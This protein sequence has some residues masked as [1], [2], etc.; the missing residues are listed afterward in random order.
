MCFY[1]KQVLIADAP[2]SFAFF[3][4]SIPNQFYQVGWPFSPPNTI[5]D[6][7]H[8]EAIH[9]VFDIYLWLSYRY[10]ILF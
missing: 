2:A 1:C 4:A 8:L 10:K 5:L 3:P 9:D 6:L 7:I